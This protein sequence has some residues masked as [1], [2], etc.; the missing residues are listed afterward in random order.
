MLLPPA[1]ILGSLFVGRYPLSPEDILSVLIGI[2][3]IADESRYETLRSII[4]YI[5]L[6]R[7]LLG[8]MVGGSLAVSGA[9]LQGLFRNPLVSPGMLGVSSGAGFGAALGIILFG[10]TF[11]TPL[12][13]FCFGLSAV[14]FSFLVGRIY[15]ARAHITLVLGG[16]VV[17]SLFSAMLSFLKYIADP[18]DQL[19]AIVFWLMGSLASAR[20]QDIFLAGIPMVAGCSGLLLFSYRINVLSMGDR[21]AS[22]LG[23]NV[24]HARIFVVL[25]TSLATAGAVCV[26]GSINWVGLIIPHMGRMIVGSDNRNLLPFSFVLGGCFMIAVDLISRSVSGSE[27][28]LGILTAFLGAPFFIFLL[29]KTRA[30]GWE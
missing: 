9:S 6:P 20:Y 19:P 29:Y 27:L 12:I 16:M 10:R 24:T 13:A 22:S 8:M 28:P 18:Y 14:A 5:R 4:L 23:V 30:R 17:S 3:G 21:E 7:A 15:N 26:S 11:M 2:N 1:V 25:C